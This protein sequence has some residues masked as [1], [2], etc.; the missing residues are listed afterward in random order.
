MRTYTLCLLACLLVIGAPAVLAQQVSAQQ[1]FSTPGTLG[2]VGYVDLLAGLAYSD[3]PILSGNSGSGD[4]IATAGFST[5]YARRGG[6]SV[7]LLGN[8]ER[9]E[10]L[11]HTYPG[12]FYGQFDGSA[13]LGKDTDPLQWQLEDTFGESVTNPLA[14]P[15]PESL[16]TINYV[17]TGPKLNLHFGLTN[18]LTLSGLYS[19]ASY[20]RAPLDSQSFQGELEFSHAI[21]EAAYMALSASTARTEYLQSSALEKF[22]GGP[23]PDFNLRQV[24]VVFSAN[25]PRTR[26]LLSAG[27]NM[28]DFGGG[29][30]YSAPRAHVR[31]SRKISPFSTVFLSGEQS[32]SM[33]GM[34]MGTDAAQLGLQMGGSLSASLAVPQPFN[35]RSGSIGW[36]FQRARTQISMAAT[37]TQTLYQTTRG[38][39]TAINNYNHLDEGLSVILSRQLRPTVTVQLQANGYTERYSQTSA[40]MRRETI[41]LTVSKQFVRLAVSF[42]AERTHQTSITGA[43]GFAA[44]S[45]ND[46][47][48]G[49]YVT[50]SFLG[51]QTLGASQNSIPGMASFMGGY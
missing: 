26:L 17:S 20:Q 23:T 15:T 22:Q 32:Y 27:Y 8:I 51:P 30:R 49:L 43:S 33:N 50:Y 36:T 13:I 45:Y 2:Q 34:A 25:S 39:S 16:Q 9:L 3:N 21:S 11:H 1:Q 29:E 24:S 12:S 40:Q 41:G 35:E 47:Q 5:N 46:D 7:N 4:G 42:Y 6:L 37:V 18:R 31:I 14:A 28:L 38:A 48:V 44:G 19:R 10:Y